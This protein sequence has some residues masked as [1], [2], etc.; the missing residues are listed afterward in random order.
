LDKKIL[1]FV[2][3]SLSLLVIV[4]CQETIGGRYSASGGGSSK[5]SSYTGSYGQAACAQ[6]SKCKWDAKSNK[7]V[8]VVLIKWLCFNFFIILL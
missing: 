3:L 7:C 5:C 6:N 8:G 2:L 1:I 4:G